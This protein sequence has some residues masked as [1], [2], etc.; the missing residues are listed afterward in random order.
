MRSSFPRRATSDSGMFTVRATSGPRVEVLEQ[1][2]VPLNPGVV[3]AL[4][5]VL[6]HAQLDRSGAELEAGELVHARATLAVIR[7]GELVGAAQRVPVQRRD[8]D[9]L[10]DG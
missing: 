9:L 1:G 10:L 6:A 7:E 4:E 3:L 2:L 8:V 5:V